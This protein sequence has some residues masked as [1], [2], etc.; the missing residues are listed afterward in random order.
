MS[1]ESV[2]PEPKVLPQRSTRGQRIT[3]LVGKDKEEDDEFYK[4]LFG[5]GD[6]DESFDSE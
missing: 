5:D 1:E 4:G 6:S 3:Q 2:A